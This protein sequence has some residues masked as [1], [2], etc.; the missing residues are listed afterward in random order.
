MRDRYD[1]NEAL[2]NLAELDE[3]EDN[4]FIVGTGTGVYAHESG[5]TARTSM[6]VGERHIDLIALA[7]PETY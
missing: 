2:D 4:E 7:T 5:A 6:G 3:V 1:Y